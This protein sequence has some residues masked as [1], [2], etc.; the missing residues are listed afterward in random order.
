[1]HQAYSASYELHKALQTISRQRGL[2]YTVSVHAPETLGDLLQTATSPL[3]V[4][5]DY[6]DKTIYGEASANHLQRAWHDAIHLELLADTSQHG[7]Y[8]VA[9]AQ[10]AELERLAGTTLAD[11]VYADLYGQTLHNIKY[12]AFPTEQ[13]QFTFDYWRTGQLTRQY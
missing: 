1:M 7:E 11:I 12:N 2:R 13:A 9:I 6:S 8:R 4:Y 5:G 10:A 3:V